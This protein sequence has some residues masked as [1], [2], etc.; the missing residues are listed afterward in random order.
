MRG[1]F[2]GFRDDGGPTLYAHSNRTSVTWDGAYVSIIVAFTTLLCAFL[3]IFP[4]VRKQRLSTFTTVLLTLVTGTLVTVFNF[5]DTWEDASGEVVTSYR[6][7]SRDKIHAFMSVNVGLY[8]ANVTLRVIPQDNRS[9]DIN[10]NERFHWITP[11]DMGRQY[12]EAL[13]K[14]LP[15]PIL[16]VA[17]YL[18]IDK[19]G[20]SWGRNYRSA[21]YYTS[22]ILWAAFTTWL[23]SCVMLVTVPRY[24]A[25]LL[26]IT[27]S[28]M[29]FACVVY[30]SLKPAVPLVIRFEDVALR[31]S[32]GA[33]FWVVLCWGCIIGVIGSVIAI[34]DWVYP[35]TFSTI[36]DIDFDTP[37]D[38]HIIILDS[39]S[40]ARGFRRSKF[41][42]RFEEPINAGLLAGSRLLRRL[43]KRSTRGRPAREEDTETN[44]AGEG[45]DNPTFS[46]EDRPK[47]LLKNSALIR[48][49]S[50][51]SALSHKSNKSVKLNVGGSPVGAVFL[52][53]PPQ[54]PDQDPVTPPLNRSESEQSRG[55]IDSGGS[56][57]KSVSFIEDDDGDKADSPYAVSRKLSNESSDSVDSASSNAHKRDSAF[58]KEFAKSVAPHEN[59]ARTQSA[60]IIVF[61]KTDSRGQLQRQEDLRS[62]LL[63]RM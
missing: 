42:Q 11:D 37:Y 61:N 30:W 34:L 2:D 21:G 44:P 18:A 31:F 39:T 35:H 14:G 6:A 28:L 7:F 5:T 13:A 49:N 19:D 26:S 56:D 41:T 62:A 24:G 40:Q 15:Y 36:L 45:V 48:T 46:M 27:G 58:M 3:V 54:S 12:G 55:S 1:W 17:E 16:T 51:K 22:I 57:R 53:I 43:S 32:L 23:L 33:S 8:H 10:F 9:L 59:V 60:N 4:G 52:N 63:L 38:R 20:F 29:V 25:Y 47:T 50:N